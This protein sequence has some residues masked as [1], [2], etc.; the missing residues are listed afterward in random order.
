MSQAPRSLESKL[1]NVAT[2]SRKVHPDIA[3]ATMP[4][5]QAKRRRAALAV[6]AQSAARKGTKAQGVAQ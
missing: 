2:N 1:F 4:A 3:A 6:R 5:R